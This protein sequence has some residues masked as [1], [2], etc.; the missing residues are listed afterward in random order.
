MIRR[1]LTSTALTFG[2]MAAPL[3]LAQE[4]VED[5]AA[6]PPTTAPGETPPTLPDDTAAPA[7]VP[8]AAPTEADMDA[9]LTALYGDAAPYKAF[10]A[11]LKTATEAEDKKA[12]T[13]M[14]DYPFT[15]KVGG[16]DKT[17]ENAAAL[18]ADYDEV[19]RPGIL[20]A[21]KN[22]TYETLFARDMGVM[23]GS[24][25]VWFSEVGEGEEKAVKII[26]INQL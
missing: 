12:V 26:G 3:A 17:F 8:E 2:L 21:I 23:I 24:G 16:E 9:Q 7:T 1:L 18:E 22:Q 19:F 4:P 11:D 5:P 13:A 10:L 20:V 25:E 14:V 6:P 15:T